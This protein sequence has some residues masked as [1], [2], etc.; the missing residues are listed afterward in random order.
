VAPADQYSTRLADR[1]ALARRI[2][3]LEQRIGSARLLLAAAAAV[4]AWVAFRSRLI[5]G[6]WLIV[7]IAAFTAAVWYHATLRRR[8]SAAERAAAFYRA[9]LARIEDRWAGGGLQGA[10][11]ADLHHV[12]AADLDLFGQGGLFELLCAARTRM[13]EEALADWLLRPASV[14]EIR[15]RQA[16]IAD[17]RDRLDMREELAALGE[18]SGIGVQPQ[19][20]LEWA[21]SPNVLD[22]ARMGAAALLLPATCLA[23]AVAWIATGMATPF[24]LTIL[25]EL[26]LLYRLRHRL[27]EVLNATESAFEDLNMFSGLLTRIEREPFRAPELEALV[28]AL[29]SGGES[30]ARCVGRLSTIAEWA[31]SRENLIV[32]MLSVPLLYS[33]QVALAA[34]RWRRAHGSVVRAWVEATGRFEALSSLAQY[35]FEHPGDPFPVFVAG[36]PAFRAA[37]LG[38]PLIVSGQ[39]VRNDVDVSGATRVLIVSGSNMSGKSTLLRSVGI[40]AVLALAGAPVRARSLEMT[41]LAVGACIRINDSLPEG[42][43]RFY[44]EITRLRQLY[45]LAAT[46][47]LLLLLDELLQGTNSKDR[48]IGA[49][50]LLRGFLDRGAIG[51][52]STHDL[53]LT[54]IAGLEDG[55]LRN[56]HFQDELVEGRMRFDFRLRE[57]IVTKS[58]GL[59]LMRSIGLEV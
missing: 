46:G 31:G 4:T 20:L 6:L 37:G 36:R 51:L 22:R 2:D 47:P 5:S 34:E 28:G 17:L 59:A 15:A 9:G 13:G 48:R 44:A 52:V 10:R 24:V 25:L 12:Y 55:S 23:A 21:E 32:K 3:V 42:S 16:S 50:A 35:S 19:S 1:E 30:A 29:S 41:P 11:F 40:N 27:T 43:S 8:R 54:E 39:C 56:V 57:G 58:N 45:E 18:H 26:A 14:G 33:L 7:P 53:A 49:E 38:H